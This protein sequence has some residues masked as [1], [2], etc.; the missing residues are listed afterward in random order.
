[1][2][3]SLLCGK[4]MQTAVQSCARLMF[5]RSS[6]ESHSRALLQAC[7]RLFD[8][9]NPCFRLLLERLSDPSPPLQAS[10]QPFIFKTT[11]AL[12]AVLEKA[13]GLPEWVGFG[14]RPLLRSNHA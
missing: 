2:W 14:S 1:M 3:G 7:G 12:Q 10:N 6:F 9:G 11:T 4:S 8:L 13:A 5:C